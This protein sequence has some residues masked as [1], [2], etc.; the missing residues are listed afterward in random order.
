[1]LLTQKNDLK[2]DIEIFLQKNKH[3]FVYDG[4]IDNLAH[5]VTMHNKLYI[6]S[7]AK[8]ISNW[9]MLIQIA[10]EIDDSILFANVSDHGSVY[11]QFS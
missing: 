1:M 7:V 5:F 9:K 4:E 11:D 8:I 10:S 3:F 6:R 2:K